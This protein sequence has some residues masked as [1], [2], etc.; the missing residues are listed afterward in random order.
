MET[1]LVI[2][3]I[4]YFLPAF[5]SGIR[6]HRNSRALCVANLFT[7]WT[8]IGWVICL[9]W[10]LT[11]QK[12]EKVITINNDDSSNDPLLKKPSIADELNKLVKLK[13]DGVLT[14]EEFQIQKENILNK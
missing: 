6:N 12:A 2:L 9:V 10:S 8:F 3:I 5:I 1:G 4:L 14:E 7:G 11:N 13:E